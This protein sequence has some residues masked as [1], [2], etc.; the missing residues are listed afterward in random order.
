MVC[1]SIS[2]SARTIRYCL[3]RLVQVLLQIFR[4]ARLADQA[5]DR[6]IRT[7]SETSLKLAP[8]VKSMVTAS[9]SFGPH[10]LEKLHPIHLRHVAVRNDHGERTLALDQGQLPLRR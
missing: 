10:L 5:E 4:R 3:E 9:L 7:A 8:P 2:F 1:S 6:P